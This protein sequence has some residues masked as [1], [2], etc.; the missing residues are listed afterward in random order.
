MNQAHLEFLASPAWAR[1]LET[2]LLPW[3]LTVGDLGDDLLEIGP[4]PG[5]TTDLLRARVRRVTAVELDAALASALAERM[6]GTSVEVV[7]AD[8]TASGLPSDRF[9]AAACFSMLHHIP[10][11]AEQDRLVAEVYRMLRPGGS[12][13]A[14][15]S[16]DL[17]VIR[18]FHEQ[19]IFVPLDPDELGDRLGS[20]G[21]T[22]IE[23]SPTDFEIR[24]SARK[25]APNRHLQKS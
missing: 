17:D 8:A 6:A 19:D 5:L 14:T 3:L 15:D 16:Q 2:E 1:W 11:R 21:F 7:H 10:T 4:G 25:P 18:A 9:S 22:R 12:F 13:V 24:F 23:V 20:A